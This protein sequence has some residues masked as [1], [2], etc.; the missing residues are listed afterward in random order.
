MSLS[1]EALGVFFDPFSETI[2][3]PDHS[4]EDEHRFVTLGE[5]GVHIIRHAA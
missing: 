2:A 4:E 1:N 5:L 3:D